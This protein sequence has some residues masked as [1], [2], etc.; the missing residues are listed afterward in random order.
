MPFALNQHCETFFCTQSNLY[1][2]LFSHLISLCVHQVFYVSDLFK[3]RVKPATPPPSPIKKELLPSSDIIE[4]NNHHNMVWGSPH[5][6]VTEEPIAALLTSHRTVEC[7]DKRQLLLV[8]WHPPPFCSAPA[9]GT[10]WT[11]VSDLRFALQSPLSLSRLIIY[12][13]Y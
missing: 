12:Y 6:L 3:P 4:R 13:N 5:R 7:S 8:E 9:G 2:V 10:L 11:R 1:L